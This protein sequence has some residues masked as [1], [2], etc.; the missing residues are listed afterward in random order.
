MSYFS[1]LSPSNDNQF[2]E[3]N[4]SDEENEADRRNNLYLAF[5]QGYK[6]K[7]NWNEEFQRLKEREHEDLDPQ[8]EQERIQKLRELCDEFAEVAKR[9]GYIDNIFNEIFSIFFNLFR[10]KIVSELFLPS[11]EKS[12]LPKTS[13][14]GGK[15]YL[16]F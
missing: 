5:Q 13:S 1:E 10:K 11:T 9:I 4:L 6:G 7:R 15:G 3:N 14:L 8:A 12:I 2:D 16:I